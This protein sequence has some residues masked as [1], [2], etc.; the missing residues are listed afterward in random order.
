MSVISTGTQYELDHRIAE[1]VHLKINARES[2]NP[3]T[4][5]RARLASTGISSG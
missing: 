5:A 1:G 3:F 4:D 2:L